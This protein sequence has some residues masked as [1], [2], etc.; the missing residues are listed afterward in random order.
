MTDS[1]VLLQM[2]K[3]FD[4][5]NNDLIPKIPHADDVLALRTIERILKERNALKLY[6]YISKNVLDMLEKTYQQ[7][8]TPSRVFLLKPRPL[9][10]YYELVPMPFAGN[11]FWIVPTENPN[12][13]DFVELENGVANALIDRFGRVS[14][15]ETHGM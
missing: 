6:Y 10:F 14:I 4:Q 8:Y 13:H 1:E 9:K 12:G 3:V 15:V 11:C 7:P 5:Y 2:Q